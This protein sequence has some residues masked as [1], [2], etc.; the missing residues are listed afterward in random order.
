MGK[1]AHRRNNKRA[2]RYQALSQTD[3]AALETEKGRLLEGWSREI[4]FR[5]RR[6]VHSGPGREPVRRVWELFERKREEAAKHGLEADLAALCSKAIAL[7][8][9]P[10]MAFRRTRYPETI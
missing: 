8:S 9:N 2:A 4:R 5:A 7:A 6:L 3:P 10:E 1:A